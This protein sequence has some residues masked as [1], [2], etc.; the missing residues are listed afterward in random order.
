VD[1]IKKPRVAGA[2]IDQVKHLINAEYHS[3][4]QGRCQERISFCGSA[5]L[6]ARD[7]KFTLMAFAKWAKN[8]WL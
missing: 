6:T 8:F 4:K 7:K 2:F 5:K 3:L 1:K